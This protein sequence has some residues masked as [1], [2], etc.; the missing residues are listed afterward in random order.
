[1]IGSRITGYF[2][3]KTI[4]GSITAVGGRYDD[5]KEVRWDDGTTSHVGEHERGLVWEYQD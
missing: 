3:D 2:V 1:M 4:G 5:I